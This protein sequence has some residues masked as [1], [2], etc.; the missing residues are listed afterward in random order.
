[1]LPSRGYKMF[2]ILILLLSG[3]GNLTNFSGETW[4]AEYRKLVPQPRVRIS[5]ETVD[6]YTKYPK[7]SFCIG[8]DR[9]DIRL[10]NRGDYSQYIYLMNR[11]TR[12]VTRTLYSGRLNPGTYYLSDLMDVMFEVE[13]PPG[14]ESL[15]V[16]VDGDSSYG[17]AHR[18]R[19]RVLDCDDRPYP[20]DLW[21]SAYVTPWSIPQGGSGVITIRT[22]ASS[23]PSVRYYFE[24]YNS[25]GHLWRRVEA[26]KRSPG[27]YELDLVVDRETPPGVLTYTVKLWS[28]TRYGYR[29]LEATNQFTFRVVDDYY[30]SR[31]PWDY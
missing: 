31:G 8:R 26:W 24:I 27:V 21:I 22:N 12:G 2:L 6:Y 23:R 15:W 19:F 17:Y 28:E 16:N 30:L 29:R 7:T 14:T 1:M 18:V 3:I 13:G 9:I 20:D 11:D 4:G 5:I 10:T 25:W